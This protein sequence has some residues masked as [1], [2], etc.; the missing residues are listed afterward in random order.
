MVHV[1]EEKQ[2]SDGANDYLCQLNLKLRCFAVIC[3]GLL[4]FDSVGACLFL[5]LVYGRIISL[6]ATNA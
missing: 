6:A 2:P 1:L 5:T 4:V 3:C